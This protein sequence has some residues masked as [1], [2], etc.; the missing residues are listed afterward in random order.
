MLGVYINIR[1]KGE[2]DGG[3]EGNNGDGNEG[4]GCW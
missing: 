1:D 2:D 4:E 3:D